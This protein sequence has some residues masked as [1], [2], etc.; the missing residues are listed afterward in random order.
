MNK[1]SKIISVIVLMMVMISMSVVVNA[2]TNDDVISYVTMTH[3]INGRT[4]RLEKMARE[5]LTQYL[6]ENPVSNSEA[7]EIIAKLSEAK[8]KLEQSGATKVSQVSDSVKAEVASLVK[9]AGEIA[10][11]DVQA[12]VAKEI[13]TIK[14]LDGKRTIVKATSFK[15][16]IVEQKN[17][18]SANGGAS[19]SAGAT[20]N[21]SGSSTN[22]TG[23]KLVYTGN[24]FS[25]AIQTIIAIVAVAGIGFGVRK[26][27]AK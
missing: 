19:N 12:D 23:N 27:Y 18:S 11:L 6:R 2:A 1:L 20:N 15:N 13:V 14:T 16:L 21:N 5:S 9:S 4:F 3:T 17:N 26:I 22:K 24:D 7:D 8:V 10:G 25:V